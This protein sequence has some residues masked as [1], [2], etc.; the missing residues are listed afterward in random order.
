MKE[1]MLM[2]VLNYI[3]DEATEGDIKLIQKV[4]LERQSKILSSKRYNYKLKKAREW[5]RKKMDK[6]FAIEN[7]GKEVYQEL[8]EEGFFYEVDDKIVR[9]D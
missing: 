8:L 1:T 9:N 3:K 5:I 6:K 4:I 2:D 7:L